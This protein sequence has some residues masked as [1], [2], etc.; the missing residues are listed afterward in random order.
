MW[1]KI[2]HSEKTKLVL[3]YVIMPIFHFLLV[4]GI[5]ILNEYIV[6]FLF[7]D[8]L[9][10]YLPPTIIRFIFKRDGLKYG[11]ELCSYML[12]SVITVFIMYYVINLYLIAVYYVDWGLYFPSIMDVFITYCILSYRIIKNDN[13]SQIDTYALSV[14]ITLYAVAWI[15]RNG[16]SARATGRAVGVLLIS[17]LFQL[18]SNKDNKQENP[19]KEPKQPD[20]IVERLVCI[21]LAHIGRKTKRENKYLTDEVIIERVSIENPFLDLLIYK[22]TDNKQRKIIQDNFMLFK[23]TCLYMIYD[24]ILRNDKKLCERI[25][26]ELKTIL[27]EELFSYGVHSRQEYSTIF[28]KKFSEA[29]KKTKDMNQSLRFAFWSILAAKYPD[30]ITLQGIADILSNDY[31]FRIFKYS[32]T[33]IEAEYNAYQ[34]S[35]PLFVS[36]NEVR[37]T[38]V[39]ETEVRETIDEHSRKTFLSKITLIEKIFICLALLNI[40]LIFLTLS[41]FL[42]PLEGTSIQQ[43]QGIIKSSFLILCAWFSVRYSFH[44]AS[45]VTEKGLARFIKC[46]GIFICLLIFWASGKGYI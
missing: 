2:R 22:F 3:A 17:L 29:F 18:F 34:A 13:P 8:L 9:I 37:E 12:L 44:M 42:Q 31:L 41:G 19:E 23:E 33:A 38:E 32:Y 24:V 25:K 46:I 16:L 30:W 10:V 5:G 6:P 20:D 15:A 26:N 28:S 1:Y 14:L 43:S 39:R 36:K 35:L 40:L 7:L 45:Q 11:I 21:G 27:S 4:S